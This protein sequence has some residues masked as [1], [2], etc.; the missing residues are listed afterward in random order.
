MKNKTT[1]RAKLREMVDKD[2]VIKKLDK[3][4]REYNK[5]HREYRNRIKQLEDKIIGDK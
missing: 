4:L 2:P 3:K 5:I 1:I